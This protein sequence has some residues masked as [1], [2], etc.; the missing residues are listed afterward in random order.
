MRTPSGVTETTTFTRS[1]GS[2]ASTMIAGPPS[3]NQLL[4]IAPATS[5]SKDN[6]KNLPQLIEASQSPKRLAAAVSRGAATR[7][8]AA[9]SAAI[10]APRPWP[11]CS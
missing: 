11:C 5:T 7:A 4:T 3:N 1:F 9:M 10:C 8:P 6:R 2:D